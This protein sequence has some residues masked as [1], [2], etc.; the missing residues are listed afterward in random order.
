[1]ARTMDGGGGKPHGW[2]EMV[3]SDRVAQIAY[4][5][6]AVNSKLWN[7]RLLVD[8]FVQYDVLCRYPQ[9]IL[10]GLLGAAL[11]ESVTLMREF[12]VLYDFDDEYVRGSGI[13]P[14]RRQWIDSSELVLSQDE[15]VEIGPLSSNEI[16]TV[17]RICQRA[18]R[19]L[20]LMDS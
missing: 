11:E 14:K 1:M 3:S 10:E 15:N 6:N 19:K 7:D 16:N 17:E 13:E 5:W 20:G 4:Q 2:R 8:Q 18:S 9:K 12:P